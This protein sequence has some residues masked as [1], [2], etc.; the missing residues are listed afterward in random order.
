M[1]IYLDVEIVL[2][3][4]DFIVGVIVYKIFVLG[5]KYMEVIGVIVS[6]SYE[7]DVE[8]GEGYWLLV[9]LVFFSIL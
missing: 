8:V 9:V 6:I 2:L 7:M 3:D 5:E 1:I 4:W